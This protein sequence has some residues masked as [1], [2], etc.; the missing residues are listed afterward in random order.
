MNAKSTRGRKAI[1][2]CKGVSVSK[3]NTCRRR[4]ACKVANLK[5]KP[6]CRKRHNTRTAK[7]SV[8]A[9]KNRT[10]SRSKSRSK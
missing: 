8:K 2:P 1:V 5:K 6:Y 3:P 7:R 9:L 4:T 10:R